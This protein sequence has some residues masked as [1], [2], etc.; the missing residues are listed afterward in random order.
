MSLARMHPVSKLLHAQNS[1]KHQ[2][3]AMVIGL[4]PRAELAAI[5][6]MCALRK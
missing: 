1:S 5:S 6:D 4:G 3:A 2:L